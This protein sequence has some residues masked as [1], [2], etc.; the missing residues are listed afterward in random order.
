[1][2]FYQ[3]LLAP[4]PLT[5]FAA[6]APPTSIMELL[7]VLFTALSVFGAT[8]LKIAQYPVGILA[9]VLYSFV[10]IDAK[11]YSSLALNVY[12][13]IIQL[14]GLWF[15]TYGGRRAIDDLHLSNGLKIRPPKI[16]D[17]SWKVVGLWGIA[18]TAIS[19][20]V[21]YLVAKYL[22][23]S[24]AFM[25][26]GILAASVLAQFLL[27]RKQLKSWY[28]WMV[29]NVLSVIV[30]GFQQH[31]VVSGVLYAVLFVNAFIGLA[32]WKKE[33]AKK[34]LGGIEVWEKGTRV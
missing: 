12:F 11:L 14:Y 2:E 31:L 25:D 10:F 4:I 16:G 32:H 24:S 15:W 7:A 30:Y 28:I 21:G 8:R 18:A 3:S 23:G 1:M 26:A 19:A 22:N 27:D 5:M 20:V 29:V 9:T 33:M 6:D 34:P 17:W 13:T